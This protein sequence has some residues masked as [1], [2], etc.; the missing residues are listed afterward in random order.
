M[1]ARTLPI[2]VPPLPG[3]AID[4]W[5]EA[6]A[7]RHHASWQDLLDALG[8]TQPRST[9][10][11][12][13]ARPTPHEMATMTAATGCDPAAITASTLDR[14]HGTALRI[15]PVTRKLSAFPWS[16]VSSSRFCPQCLAETGGRW[17]LHWRLAWSF[18]CL[19][20]HR[21]LAD[22]CP[23][24]RHR[25][26]RLPLPGLAVPAPGHCASPRPGSVGIAPVRCGAD[27]THAQTLPLDDGHPALSGQRRIN[28]IIDTG[29]AAFGIYASAP[30]PGEAALTD[31]KIVADRVLTYSTAA[32]LAE[33]IPPDMLAAHTQATDRADTHRPGKALPAAPTA[34]LAIT[35][36][37]AVLGAPDAHRGGHTLRWLIT[38]TRDHWN[39]TNT[40]ALRQTDASPVLDAIQLAALAPSMH[41]GDQLRRRITDSLPRR[42]TSQPDRIDALAR[43]LPTMLWPAWSL[44]LA[45]PRP[46][47]RQLRPALSVALMLT[48]TTLPIADAAAMLGAHT[49]SQRVNRALNLLANCG[50]WD[51]IRRA[52]TRMSDHLAQAGTPIDYQRRR[53]LDYT[54]LLPDDLWRQICREN[55]AVALNLGT[56]KRVRCWLFERISGLPSGASP[57]AVDD[58]NHFRTRT[59]DF[60]RHLTP[61][62]AADLDNHTLEFLADH[63]IHDEPATWQPPSHPLHDLSLPGTDPAD[64]EIDRLHH[65]IRHDGHTPGEAAD[66]LD[67]TLDVVRHLLEI[68]PPPSAAAPDARTTAYLAV[69]AAL[70]ADTLADLYLRQR[71]S[72]ATIAEQFGT[73][74]KVIIHL[75]RDY[76]IPLRTPGRQL[77][78]SVDRDWLHEQY[79]TLVRSL[80]QLA[81]EAGMSAHTLARWADRYNIPLRRRPRRPRF[82]NRPNH[83]SPADLTASPALLQQALTNSDHH[84][85]NAFVIASSHDTLLSAAKTIGCHPATIRRRIYALEQ[86]LGGPLLIRARS[87]VAMTLTPLGQAVADAIK[88]VGNGQLRATTTP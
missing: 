12:W 28:D 34:A 59:A 50:H 68:H 9:V 81:P 26:R 61:Q 42:P 52:L 82:R 76:R 87:N 53:S 18:A 4:S 43:S 7:T 40:A 73:F 64:T 30:M 54:D 67:T 45:L 15:D 14:Y 60:V 57:A 55:G 79:I 71:L 20:H 33:V 24:C 70:P 21:L 47:Q 27:L 35:T 85:L 17:Q 13:I 62:L 3:E 84:R 77:T 46:Q 48:G 5:I 88:T 86:D 83:P 80:K 29:T 16:P 31:L 2:R 63:G 49:D 25:Q 41:P 11:G 66:S 74:D 44:R 38:E 22:T 56:A 65:L 36:A 1:S 58:S 51:D 39:K 69:K 23:V 10:T 6:L 72:T 78:T 37:L 8:L 32:A 75:A 19:R